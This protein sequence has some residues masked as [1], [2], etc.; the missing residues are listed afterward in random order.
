MSSQFEAEVASSLGEKSSTCDPIK[1]DTSVSID[2]HA[3]EVGV[4][5]NRQ[6]CHENFHLFNINF[7]LHKFVCSDVSSRKKLFM[8]FSSY[9][10][11]TAST[12]TLR[13]YGGNVE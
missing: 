11:E 12:L 6:K 1:S 3:K 7:K 13:I 8:D 4:F 10:W 2:L 5:I 9:T